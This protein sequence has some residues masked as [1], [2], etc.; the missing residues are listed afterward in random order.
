[1]HAYIKIHTRTSTIVTTI[2]SS[3]KCGKEAETKR[4]TMKTNASWNEKISE[5]PRQ[6][7]GVKAKY[8]LATTCPTK[9]LT[10]V[11]WF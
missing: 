5:Q 8:A 4:S 3:L 9:V 1:M 6:M 2:V 11:K 7:T 10:Q